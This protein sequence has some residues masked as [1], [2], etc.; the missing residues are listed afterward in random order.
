MFTGSFA[1]TMIVV[2]AEAEFPAGKDIF[3]AFT[4]LM[5]AYVR[6]ALL[7]ERGFHLAAALHCVPE[8]KAA[9][10]HRLHR[11][12]GA[13]GHAAHGQKRRACQR[14]HDQVHREYSSRTW[15][16]SR[17]R[18]QGRRG[19]VRM[20]LHLHVNTLACVCLFH[21]YFSSRPGAGAY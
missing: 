10:L 13:G 11:E 12:R 7:K 15:S 14:E 3:I 16:D 21:T 8:L 5:S 4:S 6:Y 18:V 9:V 19:W 20:C 1:D 17:L 2:E